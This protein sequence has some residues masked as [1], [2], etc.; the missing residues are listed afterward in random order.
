MTIIHLFPLWKEWSK[1]K[2]TLKN[3]VISYKPKSNFYSLFRTD[4]KCP[5]QIMINK[6]WFDERFKYLHFFLTKSCLTHLLQSFLGETLFL[7]LNTSS[8]LPKVSVMLAYY[9]PQCSSHVR[10]LLL[11]TFRIAYEKFPFNHLQKD[12]RGD[13]HL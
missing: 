9:W 3:V 10:L 5:T 2:N 13:N 7:C 11:R 6:H 1:C 4:E 8:L 12:F